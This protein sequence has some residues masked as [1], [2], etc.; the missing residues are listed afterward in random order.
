VVIGGVTVVRA[1]ARE[2]RDLVEVEL[3]SNLSFENGQKLFVV[4][5]LILQR[6]HGVKTREPEIVFSFSC[7]NCGSPE[8]VNP[9]G[10]CGSCG[11][12]VND[13]RFAWVITSRQRK[14][15]TAV[16]PVVL[17]SSGEELGTDLPTVKSPNL[18]AAL[19]QLQNKD[20]D[21]S[22][23]AF[24]KFARETF[25]ALQSA[26]TNKEWE[27][28]RPLETDFLFQ[29]HQYWMDCYKHDGLRNVLE[30]IEI[31]RID[32]ARIDLDKFFESVTIRIFAR[33]KDYTIR[34]ANN[35]VLSGNPT[36]LRS[37][38][39]YWTFVRRAGVTSKNREATRCPNCGAP[40]DKVTHVGECEYCQ[41]RITRG[42]FDW[43]L[44]RIEQDE[45]YR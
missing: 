41:A 14:H 29:Q 34:E 8:G 16:P 5:S 2:P 12:K 25:M 24:E 31:T 45:A 40:L 19:S 23:D 44:S 26:W 1:L 42:D 21:F 27:K 18:S 35:D 3:E 6:H 9:D 32:W 30:D 17:S 15:S 13:G 43:I 33:M 37:F 11:E 4:E 7:P 22:K 28:A 38:S 36:Q 20:P 10:R 39:E